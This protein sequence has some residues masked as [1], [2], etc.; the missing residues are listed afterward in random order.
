M[1][2]HAVHDRPP[3][4]WPYGNTSY[5]FAFYPHIHLPNASF[6]LW[7]HGTTP[8]TTPGTGGSPHLQI[9]CTSGPPLIGH[10]GPAIL[11]TIDII[12]SAFF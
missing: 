3:P 4:L 11:L 8:P 10:P 5:N 6:N 9:Y 7:D 2:G 1:N 12:G